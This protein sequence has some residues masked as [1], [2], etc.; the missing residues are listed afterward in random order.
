MDGGEEVSGQ[1]VEALSNAA[2]IFHP[3]EET[4][5]QIAFSIQPLVIR[6]WFQ[7]VGA[8]RNDWHR[9]IIGNSLPV[10]GAV[11]A[12]VSADGEW[13]GRVVQQLRQNGAVMNLTAG[14]DEVERSSQSIDHGM[15][16]RCAAA[17]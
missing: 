8:V 16:L 15:E 1:F 10:T 13:R 9:A 7:C 4:L 2:H 5:D 6:L 17:A 3:A 14:Q 12:L 11:V